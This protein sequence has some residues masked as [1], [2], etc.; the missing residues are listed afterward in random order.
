[1]I[2]PK[3]LK[4]VNNQYSFLGALV[5]KSKYLLVM[6]LMTLFMFIQT[7]PAIF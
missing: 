1:M 5:E 4:S 3:M 7:T 2:I 6:H